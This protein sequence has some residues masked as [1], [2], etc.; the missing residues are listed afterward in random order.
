VDFLV[1]RG[2]EFTAIE[3]KAKETLTSRDFKGL[4]AIA[5]LKGIRRR[6]VVFLGERPFRTEDGI[7]ALPVAD[8]LR[9]LEGKTI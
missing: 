9:E 5:D 8:F 6:L 7:E 4:K 3:V 1:Q 2:H